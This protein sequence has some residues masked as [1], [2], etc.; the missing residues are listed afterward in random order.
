MQASADQL[1]D[2]FYEDLM[3]DYEVRVRLNQGTAL[4]ATFSELLER[5]PNPDFVPTADQGLTL[6]RLRLTDAEI[7]ERANIQYPPLPPEFDED[8][9]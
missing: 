5:E 9:E 1:H 4:W 2:N 7:A 3:F 6:G 8:E